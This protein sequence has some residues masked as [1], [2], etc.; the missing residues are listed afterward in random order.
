MM[1]SEVDLVTMMALPVEQKT[2]LGLEIIRFVSEGA[3]ARHFAKGS[4]CD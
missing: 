1:N 4:N 3:A 2:N